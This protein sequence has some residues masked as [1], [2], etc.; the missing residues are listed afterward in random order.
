MPSLLIER[1]GLQA[2]KKAR[3]PPTLHRDLHFPVADAIERERTPRTPAPFEADLDRACAEWLLC[4]GREE[5]LRNSS[6]LDHFHHV[7]LVAAAHGE[8]RFSPF[9]GRDV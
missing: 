1:H 3:D 7:E 4:V 8:S 9:A 5:S 2:G 6:V